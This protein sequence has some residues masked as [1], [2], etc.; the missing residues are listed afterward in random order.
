VK[1]TCQPRKLRLRGAF[2]NKCIAAITKK[3]PGLQFLNIQGTDTTIHVLSDIGRN[4]PSL[5]KL[6]LPYLDLGN[7]AVCYVKFINLGKHCNYDQSTNGPHHVEHN[8]RHYLA[9]RDW[10]KF[11]VTL[12]KTYF[13]NLRKF[14]ISSDDAAEMGEKFSG[15]YPH[16]AFKHKAGG[17]ISCGGPD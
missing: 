16:V 2:D 11:L 12:P 13:Q 4:C 5:W 1:V 14:H 3:M 15:K 17:Y 10:A 6:T 8:Y 9:N 7:K